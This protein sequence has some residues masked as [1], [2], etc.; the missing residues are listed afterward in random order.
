[1]ER[2][3]INLELAC[4]DEQFTK[5]NPDQHVLYALLYTWKTRLMLELDDLDKKETAQ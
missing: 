3:E 4:I 1:M 2:P 5:L